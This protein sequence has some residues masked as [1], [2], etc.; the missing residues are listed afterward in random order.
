MTSSIP[1]KARRLRRGFTLVEMLVVIGIILLLIGIALPMI[2]R[3]YKNAV[4]TRMAADLQVISM[5]LEAYKG[6]HRDYPRLLP[7]PA[8]DKSQAR[9]AELLCWALVGPGNATTDT[10]GPHDGADG[11]GFRVRG[12]SGQ[13]YGPYIAT[14]RFKISVIGLATAPGTTL[15]TIN[16]RYNH[17]ILY[18]PAGVGADPQAAFVTNGTTGARPM[19]NQSDNS[20]VPLE[21]MQHFLGDLSHDGK[22]GLNE[23]AAFTGPYL[24]WSPGTDE[25]YGNYPL[26]SLTNKPRYDFRM[27]D[28]TNVGSP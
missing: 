14:G 1:T 15:P 6:D 11:L 13:V 9:G 28:I 18:F 19:Y 24:L 25:Q 16:D 8:I 7:D 4:R 20:I 2:N 10:N 5:G 12:T 23:S 27:D 17:P 22:I 26:D 21:A 3:T